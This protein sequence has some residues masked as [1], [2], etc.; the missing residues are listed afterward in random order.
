SRDIELLSAVFTDDGVFHSQ[1]NHH[2][3]GGKVIATEITT[4]HK[5]KY[6]ATFHLVGNQ[7]LDIKGDTAN[8]ETY[9]VALHW[10]VSDGVHF[11]KIVYVRYQ[12]T[13]VRVNG[14]WKFKERVVNID[15]ARTYEVS[16][17]KGPLATSL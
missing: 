2:A 13:A 3:P 17:D 16:S 14:R 1:A 4:R 11:E 7:T 6:S 15:G 12:D 5:T 8:G 10:Y 9:C